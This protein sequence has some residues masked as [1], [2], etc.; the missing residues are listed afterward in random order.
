MED[1]QLKLSGFLAVVEMPVI[2]QREFV[3]V[4]KLV[5]LSQSKFGVVQA[6]LANGP[7]VNHRPVV[8]TG[9]KDSSPGWLQ[10]FEAE[11]SLAV[12]IVVKNRTIGAIAVATVAR[13]ER[14]DHVW[15][16]VCEIAGE[17]SR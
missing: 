8:A 13:I 14:N 17:L 4:T 3:E 6:V 12:P 9:A 15:Q 10:R 1:D 7:A 11:S 2:V 16:L 5:S